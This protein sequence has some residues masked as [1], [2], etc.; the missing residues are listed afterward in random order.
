VILDD[1]VMKIIAL[2]DDDEILAEGFGKYPD[3]TEATISRE[4]SKA[5]EYPTWFERN[6]EAARATLTAETEGEL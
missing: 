1:E 6:E 5:I 3:H 2:L 4:A